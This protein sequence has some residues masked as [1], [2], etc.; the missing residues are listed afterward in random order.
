MNDVVTAD[1]VVRQDVVDAFEVA[2]KKVSPKDI[3]DPTSLEGTM[4]LESDFDKVA[5]IQEATRLFDWWQQKEE[6]WLYDAN[7]SLATDERKAQFEFDKYTVY[8]DAGFNEGIYYLDTLANDW[9]DQDE[10]TAR[11]H[12]WNDLADWIRE[13]REAINKRIEELKQA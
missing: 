12:G 11:K 2:F 6:K 10:Y 4:G 8:W 5:E 3:K 1:N 13:V 7:N 9:L